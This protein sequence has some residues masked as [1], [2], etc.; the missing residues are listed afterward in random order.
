LEQQV[1]MLHAGERSRS[2]V[3]ALALASGAARA[4]VNAH[5]RIA[6]GA[7]DADVRQRLSG[8]PTGGQP[9]LILRPHL[10]IHHDQVQAAH[11]ATWGALP[12]D[13]LF[14]ARQRGLDERSARGLIIEGMA[15][16]LFTRAFG[17][18][19][20]VDAL[21][22]AGLLRQVVAQHLADDTPMTTTTREAP[23]G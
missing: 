17:D 1:R 16:A 7:A 11:G 14:Y 22:L 15:H 6:A 2:S 21:D 5:T 3:E 9:K 10:E 23:H 8:V 4:V 20:P 12:E 13:A 18:A 19:P